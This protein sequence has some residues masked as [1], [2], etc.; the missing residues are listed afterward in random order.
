MIVLGEEISSES[1]F[2]LVWLIAS[3]ITFQDS[4]LQLTYGRNSALSSST[5]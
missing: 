5:L 2:I 1:R 4:D 3:I